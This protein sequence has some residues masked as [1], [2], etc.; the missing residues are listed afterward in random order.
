[1]GVFFVRAR[2]AWR[3]FV[4][5]PVASGCGAAPWRRKEPWLLPHALSTTACNPSASS[6]ARKSTRK[7]QAHSPCACER[8]CSIAC[9]PLAMCYFLVL[10]HV[11]ALR[12]NSVCSN[13]VK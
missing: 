12:L 13:T 7:S 8:M 4:L 6:S 11:N 2:C 1:V 10:A 9:C 5:A 3:G